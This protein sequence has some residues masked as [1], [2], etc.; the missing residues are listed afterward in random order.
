M[1]KQ[2]TLFRGG[3]RHRQSGVVLLVALIMLIAMTLGGLA[4]MRS[5]DTAI[6]AAGNLSFQQAATHS[7]DVGIETATAW[8]ENN[9]TLLN[10]DLP[11]SGYTAN[12]LTSAPSPN[13]GESWNAYWTRVWAARPPVVLP[14]DPNSGNT[15]S[16]VVDRLCRNALAPTAGADCS[17]SPILGTA[18]GNDE[19]SGVP[20]INVATKVYY[21][22][23]ARIQGP[24]NT[25]SY[26]QAVIAR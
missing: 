4:L 2:P 12:G 10:A 17:V 25:L 26:V 19:E 1:L 20:K 22:I 8:V 6:L 18:P 3:T 15:V 23:T 14:T 9:P 16:Y 11:A 21:R 13:A 7:G 24:R 5:V